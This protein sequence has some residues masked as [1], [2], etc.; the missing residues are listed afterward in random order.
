MKK[1]FSSSIASTLCFLVLD[2]SMNFPIQPELFW[3]FQNRTHL[4]SENNSFSTNLLIG[5]LSPSRILVFEQI[6]LE[7][8][9][10]VTARTIVSKSNLLRGRLKTCSSTSEWI[11]LFS[12]SNIFRFDDSRSYQTC[13]HTKHHSLYIGDVRW[14]RK[15]VHYILP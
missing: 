13:S 3:S 4:V 8:S 12:P 15:F 1:V 7:K 10:P 9:W 14:A 5:M 2:W 6:C 11:S